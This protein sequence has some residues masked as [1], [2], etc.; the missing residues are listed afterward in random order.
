MS[1][2]VWQK[3]ISGGFS[4]SSDLDLFLQGKT[5]DGDANRCVRDLVE[6]SA[7][8]ELPINSG[9]RV[10]FEGSEEA[11]FTYRECPDDGMEGTVVTVRSATG[12]L[13]AYDGRLF[14]LWDSGDLTPIH[15]SHL[16]LADASAK[17]ASSVRRVVAG[18][19]D[20]KPFAKRGEDLVHKATKDLWSFRQDG[21]QFVI[22]RLFEDNGQPLKV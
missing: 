9:T 11:L 8:L 17:R 3:M 7:G 20:L 2:D 21:G 1:D 16:R 22:E 4:R 18:P 6:R 13:N 15:S 10:A 19:A 12:D 14:I 5:L